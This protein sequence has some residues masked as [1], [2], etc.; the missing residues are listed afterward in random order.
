MIIVAKMEDIGKIGTIQKERY[1][2]QILLMVK[3]F[4]MQNIQGIANKTKLHFLNICLHINIYLK[5]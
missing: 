5:S 1:I 3:L 4:L 2:Y